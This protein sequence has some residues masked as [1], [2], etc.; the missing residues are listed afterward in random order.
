MML[1]VPGVHSK[2]IPQSNFLFLQRMKNCSLPI[3]F[4]QIFKAACQRVC[5]AYNKVIEIFTGKVF[6]SFNSAHNFSS[7]VLIVGLFSVNP[8]LN[9][10]YAFMW[11]SAI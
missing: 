7:Y 6:T 2:Q 3:I 10:V 1:S 11:L 8:N 9:R 4:T 5:N